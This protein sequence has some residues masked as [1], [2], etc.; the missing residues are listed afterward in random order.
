MA[1]NDS[2]YIT[3]S[4]KPYTVTTTNMRGETQTV[5]RRPPLK[6]HPVLPTD[7]VELSS[8]RYQ[9]FEEGDEFEVKHVNRRNPNV[10]HLVDDDGNTTFI[11]AQHV[12]LE[13][14]VAPRRGVWGL[15]HPENN[16]YLRWP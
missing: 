15:D 2:P 14:M 7:I 8:T 10:L 5:R 6:N 9:D 16:R 1:S 13:E 3:F 11:E 4:R 12:E